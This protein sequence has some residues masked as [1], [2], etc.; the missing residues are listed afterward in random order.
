MTGLNLR[1]SIADQERSLSNAKLVFRSILTVDSRESHRR[2]VPMRRQKG[3][4]AVR[5]SG[6]DSEA[7]LL[8]TA[9]QLELGL[10]P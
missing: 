5:I 7:E 10:D 2:P 8:S 4:V 3:S 9:S 1:P 6:A